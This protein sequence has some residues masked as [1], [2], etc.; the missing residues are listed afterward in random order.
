MYD[1]KN[2]TINSTNPCLII[3]LIDQSLSMGEKFGNSP[4]SKA[5]EL[6]NAINDTIY[7]AGLRC[8]SG[9]GDIKN[10]FEFSIIGYGK[11]A[12]LVQSAW[13]GQL[14]GK[15]VVSIKNIFDYPLAIEGDRPIWIRPHIGNNTPMTKAFE[16]AKRLCADWIN[17]GNHRDCHPP[18]IMN[19]TDGQATD[20]GRAFQLLKEEIR[21]IKNLSTN[22]GNVSVLNIHLS[23]RSGDQVRFPNKMDSYDPFANLLFEMSTPLDANMIQLARKFGYNIENDAQGY[24]FNGNGTDLINFLNIGTPQ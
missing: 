6:A 11:S 16:N 9:S 18:I 17:W 21:Q 20:G 19:F 22:Y 2:L 1:I 5:E 15:W 24:V 14:E 4:L 23:S 12:N 7:D 3:Y 10:R 8:V 13:E